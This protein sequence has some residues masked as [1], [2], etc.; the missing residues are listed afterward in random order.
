M[1][2]AQVGGQCDGLL[3][4]AAAALGGCGARARL[5]EGL[6][7]REQR[8]LRAVARRVQVSEDAALDG[9]ALGAAARAGS[10]SASAT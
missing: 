9:L 4:T 5:G 10:A 1:V 7:R 2:A 6:E 3:G 8:P